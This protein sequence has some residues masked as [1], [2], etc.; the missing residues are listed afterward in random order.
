[1]NN[2][3]KMTTQDTGRRQTKHKNTTEKSNRDPIKTEGYPRSSR[4][5]KATGTIS[6]QRVNPGVH[7]GKSNRDHIKT[8]G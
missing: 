8:E 6:K 3:E 5:V 1:M 4:R 2:P 7:E